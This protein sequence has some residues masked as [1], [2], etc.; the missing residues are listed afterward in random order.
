MKQKTLESRTYLRPQIRLIP[1][2]AES[3]LVQA[4][5]QHNPIGGGGTIGSSKEGI[6]DDEEELESEEEQS[7]YNAWGY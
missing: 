6:F 4:S 3:L 7:P 2:T 1:L 5:G